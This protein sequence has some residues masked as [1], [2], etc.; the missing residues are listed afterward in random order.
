[1]PQAPTIEELIAEREVLRR[2]N[3]RLRRQSENR[4]L[5]IVRLSRMVEALRKK[6]FGNSK[7]E[8][9]DREQLLMELANAERELACAEEVAEAR[10]L[11]EEGSAAP[12]AEPAKRRRK[13]RD[14]FP[15][16]IEEV[17]ETII[18]EEVR[19][20]PDAWEQ[21]GEPEVTE[22]L[23]IEPMRFIKRRTVRPRFRR[24][25]DR[26]RPPVVAP[27]PPRVLSGGLPAVGLL[28]FILLAK[29]VDHMP[30]YRIAD[31]FKRR[32][33][34]RVS[35]QTM[36]DWV[37]V[38]AEDWLGLIY[39]SI[40]S[41]L[42][43]RSYLHADETPITCNDPDCK[44]RSRKGYMW[45]YADRHGD[46]FYDWNMSRGE[47]AATATLAGYRGLVQCDAYAVYKA[48]SEKEGFLLVGCMAHVRRR[49]REAWDAGEEAASAWY[50]L[51]IRT[52]YSRER[53]LKENGGDIVAWRREHSLPVLRAVRERLEAELPAMA[54]GSKVREA[55]EY[56]LKIWPTLERYIHYA[57]AN[58]D[59]NPVE[60]AIR[61]TKLGAKNWL[62]IGHPLAGRRSAILY[63]ILQNCRN[64]D[65]NPE[66]YLADVL[67]RL[68]RMTS[69]PEAIR[70]LQPGNWK[71]ERSA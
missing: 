53:E 43:S 50:L 5:E 44:G 31:I 64:H 45:V 33:G 4:E 42:L 36:A 46:C 69:N 41:D 70:K 65:V 48:L 47:K 13:V 10:E 18:P 9:I 71:K 49:F 66:E 37:R 30:L 55:A 8:K 17:T 15:E 40:K 14:R 59:N 24:K 62:F 16:K 39:H 51:Q 19:A 11:V 1:M 12:A 27:A 26:S 61:P 54:H 22:T 58:I 29:Y 23:D 3:E 6:L 28:V 38:V 52:L 68:P 20:E 21:I 35:R 32:Y 67:H 57:D 56:T 60:Q 2:E 7:S 34:V 25:D 63:T